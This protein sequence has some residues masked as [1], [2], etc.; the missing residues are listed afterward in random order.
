MGISG[1]KVGSL[2]KA[3]QLQNPPIPDVGSRIPHDSQ[4]QD[5]EIQAAGD[6]AGYDGLAEGGS[7]GECVEG[8]EGQPWQ[9]TRV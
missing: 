9:N 1:S 7:G 8:L 4:R 2:V 5:P 6:G 3:R